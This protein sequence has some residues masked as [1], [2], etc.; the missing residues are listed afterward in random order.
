MATGKAIR[1]DFPVLWMGGMNS[2]DMN[3]LQAN[4]CLLAV[5]LCWSCEVIIYAG[6][7]DSVSPFATICVTSLIG[8]A[9]VGI[10]FCR[11]IAASFRRDG[12]LLARR[13]V[14]LSIMNTAYNVLYLVGFSYFDTSTGS[15]LASLNVVAMPLMLLAMKR[16]VSARTWL[17]AS[18]VLAGIVVATSSAF[19]SAQA[20]VFAAFLVAC[21]IRTFYIVKLND[22]AREHNPLAL[23]AGMPIVNAAI[24]LIPWVVTQPMTFAAIPW[25]TDL[26]SAYFIYAYFIVAFAG[27]LNTMA[28]R[29]A[30]AAQATIIYSTK[31]AFTILWGAVLPTAIV[32]RVVPTPPII[33]GCALVIA[34]SL[35]T[36]APIGQREED[37]EQEA[38]SCAVAD[39]SVP[40]RIR[41][42]VVEIVNRMNRPFSRNAAMFA[43]LLAF[44]LAIALPFKE[45]QIIPGFGDVRPVDMLFPVYGIFFGVPGCVTYAVGNLIGDILSDSLR[46]S[47][48]AGF[49]GN[50]ICPYLMYLV[51]TQLRKEPFN[52]RRG[53]TVLLIVATF[54]ACA[55]IKALIITPAV[56]AF[57]PEV[58]AMLFAFTVVA[59][60]VLFPTCFAIPFIILLQEE[61]GYE[62]AGKR[63][64]RDPSM[65]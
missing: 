41:D 10:C 27:V 46:W 33:I 8:G 45:L 40:A 55:C 39:P 13:I 18:C 42:L 36:I 12:W 14:A 59:N 21:V 29:R 60:G 51:W 1:G 64:R 32:E 26:V 31:I 23:A 37:G 24:S 22:Y 11:A 47:S 34:G 62:P 44:Y 53:R 2:R 6:I 63:R 7:P 49:V 4:I 65:L 56:Y 52:L 28:Q 35:V 25:S 3:N 50:L 54:I 61:L 17:S 16:G 5:T 48:I 15:F 19:S 20:P 43:V 57:Y 58:D 9:L 38:P 30:S